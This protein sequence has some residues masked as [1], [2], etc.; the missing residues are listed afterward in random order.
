MQTRSL[1]GLIALAL[2]MAGAGCT[3][4]GHQESETPEPVASEAA[5]PAAHPSG[6]EPG[7]AAPLPPPGSGGTV[8]G[9]ARLDGSFAPPA[10]VTMEGDDYCKALH[11]TPPLAESVVTNADGTLRNVFVYI[12][13]GLAPG[14]HYAAP[15]DPVL[16][17][18]VGCEYKPHVFGIMVGQPLKIRNSD[19]TLHNIRSLAK[20]SRQ[21]NIGMPNKGQQVTK[22]FA[23]QEVMVRIKCDVHPWMEC[24]AGVMSHPFFAVS[25]DGGAFEIKAVP[26]GTYTLEAWHEKFGTQTRTVTIRTGEAVE[27]SFS[28][29][30]AA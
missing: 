30:A 16:L 2:A 11:A 24:W 25:G 17:D 3:G 1:A 6:A 27:L 21:F 7:A 18:Q 23:A 26:P 22:E 15:A 10:A 8:R 14:Q 29:R 13:E 9:V 12:K 28:F 5:S 19:G 4:G 20:N